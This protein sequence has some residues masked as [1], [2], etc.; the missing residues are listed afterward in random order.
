MGS[1]EETPPDISEDEAEVTKEEAL[2]IA[3][4]E[5]QKETYQYQSWESDFQ[6]QDGSGE[7]IPAGEE[8]APSIGWPGTDEDGEKLYRGQALWSVFF[9]DQNDPLTTLTVYVDA[10]TG[11]VVGVGAR[12]D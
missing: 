1:G 4:E 5:A 2:S 3:R 6:A 12:S 10:M 7:F 9:V 8:L 11:D